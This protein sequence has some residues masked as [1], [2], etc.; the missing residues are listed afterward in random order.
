MG[1]GPADR[2]DLR[3]IFQ[4]YMA[5]S[6]Q[7][8]AHLVDA[9]HIDNRTPVDAPELLRVKFI[10]QLFDRL[11]DKRFAVFGDNRGRPRGAPV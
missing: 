5:A 10:N 7:R 1:I 4:F 2:E 11:P 6:G 9:P 3:A 8:T